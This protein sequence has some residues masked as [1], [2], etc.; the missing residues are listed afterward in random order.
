MTGRGRLVVRSEDKPSD[1]II[2]QKCEAMIEYA[3]AALRQFPKSERHVLAAEIRR[4]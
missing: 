3:H 2:R 4:C 1:L